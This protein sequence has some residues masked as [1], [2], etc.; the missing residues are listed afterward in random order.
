M[1]KALLHFTQK[2]IDLWQEQYQTAPYSENY[3][4]LPSPCILTKDE[5]GVFWLPKI[6]N[7]HSFA[8]VEEV[9]NLNINPVANEFYCL[10][11]SGDLSAKWQNKSI[12]LIQIWSDEDFRNFEGNLLA[13]LEMQRKRNLRPTIFIGT[14]D[15]ESELISIDN[16]TGTIILEKLG[17]KTST[18]LASTLA[19]FLTKLIPFIP[20]NNLN[21]E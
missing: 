3:S 21:N 7:K 5:H 20:K 4:D 1:T 17:E 19:I 11:F 13:H 18:E 16:Q 14:T 12:S 6:E 2:Y 8:I 9:M 15:D 10:Q